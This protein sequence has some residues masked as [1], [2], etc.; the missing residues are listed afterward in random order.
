[1]FDAKEKANEIY[2]WLGSAVFD[3]AN[4]DEAETDRMYNDMEILQDILGDH[5]YDEAEW[6]DKKFIAI[7]KEL[8][9]I[10]HFS[11]RLAC[12]TLIN[13]HI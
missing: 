5:I 3:M 4:G 2:D 8:K 10:G 1:M 7:A 9:E 6:D 12:Q 11:V 13:R